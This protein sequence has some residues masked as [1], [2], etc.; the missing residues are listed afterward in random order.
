MAFYFTNTKKGIIMTQK[1]KEDY[2]NDNICRFCEK[3]LNL[4]KFVIIAI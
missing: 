3:K 4:I 1:D 2:K